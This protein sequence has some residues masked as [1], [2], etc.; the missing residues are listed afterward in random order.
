[1]N[2]LFANDMFVPVSVVL[3]VFRK[4]AVIMLIHV[5]SFYCNFSKDKGTSLK[6]FKQCAALAVF[7][8]VFIKVKYICVLNA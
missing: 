4:F 6:M 5:K 2:H 8:L 1:V 3:I 7:F